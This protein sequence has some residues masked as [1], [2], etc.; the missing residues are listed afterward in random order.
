MVKLNY[1]YVILP[2][3]VRLISNAMAMN[4]DFEPNNTID[5]YDPNFEVPMSF[6]SDIGID[7]LFKLA[8]TGLFE[9][10]LVYLTEDNMA[11]YLNNEKEKIDLFGWIDLMQFEKGDNSGH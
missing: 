8:E 2:K 3:K 4:H 7:E 5:Y 9:H 11:F 10:I 6:A 1:V